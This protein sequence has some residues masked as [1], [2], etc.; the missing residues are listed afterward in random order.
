MHVRSLW[1][2][3]KIDSEFVF[4][5]R[6]KT[7]QSDHTM[8]ILANEKEDFERLASNARPCHEMETI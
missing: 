2:A 5:Q 4:D 6:L 3:E 8:Q 1:L 7:Y